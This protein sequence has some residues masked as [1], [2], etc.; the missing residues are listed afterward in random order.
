MTDWRNKP[1]VQDFS[2][3]CGRCS[4]G[5]LVNGVCSNAA[6]PSKGG[7]A[8]GKAAGAAGATGAAAS[9]CDAGL[10]PGQSLAAVLLTVLAVGFAVAVLV[11]LAGMMRGAIR[12]Q[13]GNSEQRGT[14]ESVAPP[15]RGDLP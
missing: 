5:M 6:C 11:M 2:K 14:S 3:S 15:E 8:F 10:A 1:D 4:G 12:S 7:S 13:P 9:S